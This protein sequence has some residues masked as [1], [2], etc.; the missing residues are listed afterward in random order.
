MIL[1]LQSKPYKLHTNVPEILSARVLQRNE[2]AAKFDV[3]GKWIET[4]SAIPR[5]QLPT[6]VSAAIAG[7]F[8]GY[9]VF[10]AQTVQRGDATRSIYEVH[11]ENAVEVVKLQLYSDGTTLNQSAKEKPRRRE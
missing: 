4:E 5:S 3:T 1:K 6:T 2:V 7:K 8:R 11:L 9:K 10:E